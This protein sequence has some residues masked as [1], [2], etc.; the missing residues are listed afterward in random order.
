MV[1]PY[2]LYRGILSVRDL[3]RILTFFCFLHINSIPFVHSYA[4][5]EALIN[6]E[7]LKLIMSNTCE[8]KIQKM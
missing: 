1:K 5:R 6:Y 8:C 3:L 2:L 7:L 4:V